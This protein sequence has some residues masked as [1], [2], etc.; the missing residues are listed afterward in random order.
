MEKL[1]HRIWCSDLGAGGEIRQ[2]LS[3][4]RNAY[5]DIL[6]ELDGGLTREFT[7][8]KEIPDF[9]LERVQGLGKVSPTSFDFFLVLQNPEAC[10]IGS[11]RDR[12]TPE[13]E[14]QPAAPIKQ[15]TNE[16]FFKLYGMTRE[17]DAKREKEKIDIMREIAEEEEAERLASA[18]VNLLVEKLS[19]KMPAI[20]QPTE[21]AGAKPKKIKT[22]LKIVYNSTQKKEVITKWQSY[23][24]ALGRARPP[25]ADFYCETKKQLEASNISEAMARQIIKNENVSKC[26]QNKKERAKR[27]GG[28]YDPVLNGR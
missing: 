12:Q 22:P 14:V 27:R 3:V 9:E 20:S 6:F 18:T 19:Q 1:N 2:L 5:G 28:F 13:K 16:E 15:L 4:K 7:P 26:K 8:E 23:K 24:R 25:I 17:E 10:C 21:E 11:I